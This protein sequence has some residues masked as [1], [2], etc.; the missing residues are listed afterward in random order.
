MVD[1]LVYFMVLSPTGE[2]L[3]LRQSDD[4]IAPIGNMTHQLL[5]AAWAE[6]DYAKILRMVADAIEKESTD[7]NLA[8]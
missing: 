6:R 5:L 8:I 3:G 2:F 1:N 4:G 7:G